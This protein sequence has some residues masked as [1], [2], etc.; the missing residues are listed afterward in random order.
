MAGRTPPEDTSRPLQ[1]L[2]GPFSEPRSQRWSARQYP[3][4][5]D[6]DLSL[7]AELRRSEEQ[8]GQRSLP[9]NLGWSSRTTAESP[10]SKADAVKKKGKHFEQ[11]KL[12][13]KQ[14]LS[15]PTSGGAAPFTRKR[16]HTP[17]TIPRR[18]LPPGT[19]IAER[20]AME[21]LRQQLSYDDSEPVQ[22]S[23]K[24]RATRP[25][26]PP[27][28]TANNER[29]LA[30]QSRAPASASLPVLEMNETETAR[31][32]TEGAVSS[33]SKVNTSLII[34]RLNQVRDFLRQ[35][36]AMFV[37]LQ[38]KSVG[39][40][41]SVQSSELSEQTTKIAKLIRQ[42][43]QQERAYVELLERSLAVEHD[44]TLENTPSVS[45]Q[46]LT[47]EEKQSE[48]ASIRDE[49]L[50]GLRQQHALLKKMLEQQQQVH[51]CITDH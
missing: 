17:A 13:P 21:S 48:S 30:T 50:Q 35:A 4:S 1:P 34:S 12:P 6:T 18:R 36:T 3:A 25:Q 42:L 49:E 22:Q 29:P 9:N 45:Q 37:T 23:P 7:A 11:V 27:S 44:S 33:V 15:S 46:S 31:P 43:K 10:S 41:Q 2:R 32:S 39:D 28:S 47:E 51:C 26:N 40:Q 5:L 19:P 24:S 20:M 16:H 8:S 38:S 14:S